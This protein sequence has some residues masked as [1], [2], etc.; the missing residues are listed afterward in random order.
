MNND[1]RKLAGKEEQL[2][3]EVRAK[4]TLEVDIWAELSLVHRTREGAEATVKNI[5]NR[6][7]HTIGQT[8][9]VAQSHSAQDAP[10]Q[11]D[12]VAPC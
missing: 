5:L 8:S 7:G 10:T 3:Y 9:R 1:V 2:G 11:K 6:C 4:G 12:R